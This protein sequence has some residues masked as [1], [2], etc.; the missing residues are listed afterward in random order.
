MFF[1]AL[2]TAR[3]A[4][5]VVRRTQ[6]RSFH[7]GAAVWSR[8]RDPRT[9]LRHRLSPDVGKPRRTS[10]ASPSK[11]FSRPGE[12]P[13]LQFA[14]PDTPS[15]VHAHSFKAPPLSTGLL[16]Q[17]QE[18][19]G[20][21]AKPTTPQAMALSHFFSRPTSSST[22]IAAETGSGK[23]LAYLL[24]ILQQL[25]MSRL[26]NEHADVARVRAGHEARI[27]PRAVIL[28]PTHELARQISDVAK[29]LCHDASHKL[30]I[31]CSSKPAYP[32]HLRQDLQKL[33]EMA[34]S[35]APCEGA[36][37]SPDVLVTTPS[38]LNEFYGRL[39]QLD[40]TQAIVV[41]EADTLLDEGFRE[42]TESILRAMP[43]SRQ[44]Q[45][46]FVTAT[47]PQSMRKY[48]DAA[49]P[50]LVTL[51]SPH[52]H[53]LPAKLSVQFVDPGSNKEMAV[54]KELFRIF[55][56][57][58]MRDDQILIFRD[59][60]TG[61]ER[62]SQYLSERNVDHVALT[63]ES[64]QRK[65]RTSKDIEP[66]LAGPSSYF[67]QHHQRHQPT[68][69]TPRVL[70]TTSLLSRGLDFGP[71]VRHVFLPD[72]GRNTARSVHAANNN[73]LELLHRAGRSARA[74][75][76]GTVVVFDKNSAPGKTKVLINHR[77]QKKG[78]VR[79]QMDLLVHALKRKK[80]PRRTSSS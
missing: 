39:L 48:L 25:H 75:R 14:T 74:G 61:V 20:P 49:Y 76:S 63:G 67:S 26:E 23:T 22:L 60:R 10:P 73:A 41:D 56:S 69:S 27:L 71:Y 15:S 43:T 57:P 54:L 29:V 47:I 46:I 66:F 77:G 58:D 35:D 45:T 80:A 18:L 3:I 21:H 42:A 24:P 34:E 52:L 72:A 30:R 70:I 2:T 28:A 78:I 17:V 62:L 1:E 51:A 44:T 31:A 12:L 7:T 11:T 33:R 79:G 53:R 59:K 68:D 6:P 50:D 9:P 55:T 37:T 65:T 36:P 16:H 40:Y 13:A 5:P 19:L 32:S 8:A 4:S 64:G 38:F